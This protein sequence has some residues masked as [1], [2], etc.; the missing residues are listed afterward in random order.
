MDTQHGSTHKQKKKSKSMGGLE[1]KSFLLQTQHDWMTFGH[2]E[3][4]NSIIKIMDKRHK[5]NCVGDA[6]AMK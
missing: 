3:M 5:I 2:L 1:T 4:Q 6:C